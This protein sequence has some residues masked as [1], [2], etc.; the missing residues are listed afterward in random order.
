GRH[1]LAGARA[2][3]CVAVDDWR[4]RVV[5]ATLGILHLPEDL[6][7]AEAKRDQIAIGWCEDCLGVGNVYE[8]G[9]TI[10][11]AVASPSPPLSAARRVIRYDSSFAPP[12]NL[13]DA[14]AIHDQGRAGGVEHGPGALEVVLLPDLIPAGGVETGEDAADTDRI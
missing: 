7:I 9:R 2:N 12:A 10:G 4:G 11:R 8:H 1:A 3:Q 5:S 13:R 6:S 14:E